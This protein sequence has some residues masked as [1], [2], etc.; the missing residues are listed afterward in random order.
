MKQKIKFV[1][2]MLVLI[3]NQS[4]FAQRGAIKGQLKDKELG[5]GLPF[6]NIFLSQ[7]GEFIGGTATDFDGWYNIGIGPGDYDLETSYIGYTGVIIENIDVNNGTKTVVDIE[8]EPY[9]RPY[10]FSCCCII[11]PIEDSLDIIDQGEEILLEETVIN[12]L[13][14]QQDSVADEMESIF[15]I[16]NEINIYPNPSSGIINIESIENVEEV[17]LVD[18]FGKELEKLVTN[19]YEKNTYDLSRYSSGNYFIQYMDGNKVMSKQLV[20]AH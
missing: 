16:K 7:N 15:A 10:Y 14:M 2:L 9:S 1:M 17:I 8:L 18:I 13:N 20:L 6:A 3:Y 12:D 19:Q 4:T 11:I 5:E